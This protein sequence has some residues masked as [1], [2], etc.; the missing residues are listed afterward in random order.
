MASLKP[1]QFALWATVLLIL[2]ITATCG[3]TGPYVPAHFKGGAMEKP[4]FNGADCIPARDDQRL[5]NQ[6]R[7]VF[8]LMQDGK[9]RTLG[10]IELATGDHAPSI[11]AQL[12]HLRKAR[13]GG[14]T[15]NR[16]YLGEGLFEYQLVVAKEV[17]CGS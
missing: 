14:H 7:R 2:A 9:W 16:R 3:N 12:R 17:S 10:A 1:V 13:F 11:S 8:G 6:L 5:T 15:V 4:Q